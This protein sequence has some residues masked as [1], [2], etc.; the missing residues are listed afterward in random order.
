MPFVDGMVDVNQ[1]H[2]T[3]DSYGFGWRFSRF[4]RLVLSVETW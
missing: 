2:N 1:Q 3:H 4:K